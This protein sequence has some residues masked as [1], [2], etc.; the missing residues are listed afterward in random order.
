MFNLLKKKEVIFQKGKKMKQNKEN[1]SRGKKIIEKKIQRR[2]K[3]G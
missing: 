3:L 1:F 2:E